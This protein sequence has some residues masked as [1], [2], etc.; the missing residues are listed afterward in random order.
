MT[1]Q[2]SADQA[3]AT[4]SGC[5]GCHQMNVKTVGPA[6]K[7]IAQ[8]HKGGDVSQLVATVKAG[9]NGSQLTWGTIPMP[10]SPAPEE[11]VRKVVEWM[12]SQ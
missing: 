7:E 9:R 1:A 5:A 6:I 4:K 11:D 8:K 2:V 3:T 10:P 12:L